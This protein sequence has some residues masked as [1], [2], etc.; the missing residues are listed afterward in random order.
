MLV[1]DRL[2]PNWQDAAFAAQPMLAEALLAKAAGIG[3]AI[4]MRVGQD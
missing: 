4:I 1:V 2:V 3:A